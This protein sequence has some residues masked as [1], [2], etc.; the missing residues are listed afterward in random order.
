MSNFRLHSPDAVLI[1]IPKTGGTS[2]RKGVWA[3]R[4]DP[5]AFGEIPAAWQPLFKFAFVRHPFSR[6]VS[7]YK[8]FTD[9]THNEPDWSM[10]HDARPLTVAAFIDIVL[11]DEIIFE[12]RRQRF[13]EKI[14]HHTIP[15]THPFNCLGLADFVGRYENLEQDFASIAAR[16]G[17]P[18]QLPHMHR[19]EHGHW[20][21]CLSQR[22]RDRLWM[23]YREDFEQLGYSG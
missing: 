22:E 8:M 23:F 6:F 9:G 3:G 20:S 13:E 12:E 14:R 17:V 4:Y 19:T 10:P 15:Q 2:I 7:A 11:D 21:H 1:H 16:V 5:P 18:A